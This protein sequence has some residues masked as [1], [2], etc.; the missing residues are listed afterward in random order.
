MDTLIYNKTLLE[1]LLYYLNDLDQK[2]WGDDIS[3]VINT[4]VPTIKLLLKYGA[5]PN[6]IIDDTNNTIMHFIV[7]SRRLVHL[8]PLFLAYGGDPNIKNKKGNSVFLTFCK[9]QYYHSYNILKNYIMLFYKYGADINTNDVNGH[10]C[11]Y[12]NF[13]AGQLNK[14]ISL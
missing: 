13:E 11:H 7:K 4:Y 8:L 12:Y 6:V 1:T 3:D 5:N 10:G 14:N 9:Y 2:M